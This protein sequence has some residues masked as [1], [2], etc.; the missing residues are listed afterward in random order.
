MLRGSL[1]NELRLQEERRQ[2]SNCSDLVKKGIVNILEIDLSVN[3]FSFLSVLFHWIF[4][5]L[6]V[7]HIK[8]L[9]NSNQCY[10]SIVHSDIIWLH[11][12]IKLESIEGFF[13]TIDFV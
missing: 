11:K 1:S 12:T 3:M 2:F 13:I 10:I 9:I 4:Q 5:V 7:H 6:P 8:N